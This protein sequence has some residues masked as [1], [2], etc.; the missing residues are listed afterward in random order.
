MRFIFTSKLVQEKNTPTKTFNRREIISNCKQKAVLGLLQNKWE[1][2]LRYS[3]GQEGG[4][5]TSN[6]ENRL[7]RRSKCD[8]D[9]GMC[10]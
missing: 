4:K 3:K 1:D 9:V 8:R 5:Q 6:K 10:E 7:F 2:N